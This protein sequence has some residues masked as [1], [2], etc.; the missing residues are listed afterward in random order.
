[1]PASHSNGPVTHTFRHPLNELCRLRATLSLAYCGS[2][3]PDHI[4]HDLLSGSSDDRQKRLRSRCPFASAAQNLLKNLAG[5]GIRASEW[6]IHKWNTE[7]CENTSRLHSFIPR[8]SDMALLEWAYLKQ[9]ELSSTAFG[10]VLGNC[11]NRVSLLYQI[12]SAAPL[13][14]QQ[15]TF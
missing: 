13:N 12:A 8:T 15:T 9:L 10:L 5:I 11:T 14:K 4:L 6:K 2:L 1:M 3:D 7:Y